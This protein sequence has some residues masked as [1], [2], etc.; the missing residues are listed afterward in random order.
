MSNRDLAKH[1]YKYVLE[2]QER[3]RLAPHLDVE[4]ETINYIGNLMD[5]H[6]EPESNLGSRGFLSITKEKDFRQNFGC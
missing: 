5:L 4:T 3:L 2:S 6:Y 1:I